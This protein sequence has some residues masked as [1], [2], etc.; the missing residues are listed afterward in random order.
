MGSDGLLKNEVQKGRSYFDIHHFA[1]QRHSAL[2]VL[3][4]TAPP[5]T[6][7]VAPLGRAV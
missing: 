4:V 2:V 1:R 3:V 7:L 5:V 6:R